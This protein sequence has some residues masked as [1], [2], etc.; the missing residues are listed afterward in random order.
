MVT[1]ECYVA[2]LN[3]FIL[4]ELCQRHNDIQLVLFQQDGMT[5]HM[6]RISMQTA[7]KMSPVCVSSSNDD[8]TWPPLSPHLCPCD[9]IEWGYLKQS[10]W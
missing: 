1:A 10:L 2:M 4:P 6:A 3:E 8:V 9:Y 5:S 7:Q